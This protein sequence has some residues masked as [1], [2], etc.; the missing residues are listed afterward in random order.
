MKS[1]EAVALILGVKQS[2]L[3]LWRVQVGI[4]AKTRGAGYTDE[5][6]ALLRSH[7]AKKHGAMPESVAPKHSAISAERQIYPPLDSASKP[8]DNANHSGYF[9]A[10]APDSAILE[11]IES[12]IDALL[13]LLERAAIAPRYVKRQDL[14]SAMDGDYKRQVNYTKRETRPKRAR[15]TRLSLFAGLHGVNE[16]TARDQANRKDTFTVTT[17][18]INS[19]QEYYVEPEQEAGLIAYWER[20]GYPYTRCPDCP[21]ERSAEA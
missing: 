14:D 9:S 16:R 18:P 6:I 10:S 11:R 12:K 3:R 13:A 17:V 15:G 1:A 21:H 7:G 20:V 8:M 19:H 2:T 4:P 5:E